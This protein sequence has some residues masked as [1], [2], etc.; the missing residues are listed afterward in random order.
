MDKFLVREVMPC[1]AC[2]QIVAGKTL[3]SHL[4]R[5]CTSSRKR[6]SIDETATTSSDKNVRTKSGRRRKVFCLFD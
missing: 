6:K 5:E 4:D 3:N 1:P 2:G